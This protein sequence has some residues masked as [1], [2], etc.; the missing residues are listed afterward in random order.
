ML[1]KKENIPVCVKETVFSTLFGF[2][3]FEIIIEDR[4]PNIQHAPSKF[5]TQVRV[6]IFRHKFSM[7]F[8]TAHLPFFTINGKEVL[9]E[10]IQNLIETPETLEKHKEIMKEHNAI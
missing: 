8:R 9:S 10:D 3:S 6:Q 1:D 2:V 7:I 4:L 5:K